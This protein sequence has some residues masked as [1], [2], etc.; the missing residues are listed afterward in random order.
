MSGKCWYN[1]SAVNSLSDNW[2]LPEYP[3]SGNYGIWKY[4]AIEVFNKEWLNS[5]SDIGIDI[6]S[7]MVFYR[8]PY[9]GT[10]GAHVDV[11]TI[12]PLNIVKF[13]FNWIIGG[14]GSKMLWYERPK[15]D[16]KVLYTPANTPYIQWLDTDL[17]EIDSTTMESSPTLVKVDVPHKVS[18][19]PAPRWCISARPR[20][21]SSI[22]WD[23]AVENLRSKKLLVERP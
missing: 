1:I 8:G 3:K 14:R 15:G 4:R 18:M 17:K 22:T 20:L 5:M 11:G 12:E 10:K 23:E 21:E 6:V 2:K 13:G 9:M 19:G 16:L 7:A